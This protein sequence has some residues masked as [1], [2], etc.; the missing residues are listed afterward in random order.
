MQTPISKFD[1]ISQQ[2]I[3]IREPVLADGAPMHRIAENSRVLD[4]NSSYAYLLW[5]RDF[6]ATSMVAEIDGELAG[7][8]TGYT[9]PARPHTL[10]VWQV[11]VDHPHRGHGL[12]VRM[13]DALVES[14]AAQG[15]TQ[16]ETTI[17]PDNPASVAMFASLARRRLAT[18]TRT[19]LFTA[20]QF[21]GG[22][23]PEDL[24]RIAPLTTQEEWR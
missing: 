20:D 5:C 10:F 13:L 12:G 17:S 8:V 21:P 24:Y 9:R 22:H 2:T 4:T 6:A 18:L 16:L 11:A 23:Q 14:C 3:E 1:A 7:F 15:V 19:P